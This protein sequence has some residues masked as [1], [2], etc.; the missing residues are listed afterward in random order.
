[1]TPKLNCKDITEIVKSDFGA[2]WNCR[3][4]GNSLEIITPFSTTTQKFVSVFI[5]YRDGAFVVSD[6]GWLSGE[7]DLYEIPEVDGIDCDLHLEFFGH[8]FGIKSLIS[9]ENGEKFFY[10]KAANEKLLSNAVYD[11]SNFLSSVINGLS[12]PREQ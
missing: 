9:G 4:R 1:M 3:Q 6:G 11:L 10:K 12:L 2:L 8:A 7:L 5:T